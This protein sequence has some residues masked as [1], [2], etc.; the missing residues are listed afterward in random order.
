MF[1]KAALSRSRLA[2]VLASAF[3]VSA[4]CAWQAP[5]AGAASPA[6]FTAYHDAGHNSF[7]F[8][9]A[10]LAWLTG[11]RGGSRPTLR[12]GLLDTPSAEDLTVTS[13][14]TPFVARV[15]TWHITKGVDQGRL[16]VAPGG[17][18]TF[19]YTVN[20]THEI[21]LDSG[22]QV[23]GTIHV[24]NPN[25]FDAAGVDVTDAVDNGGTCTV[26]GD[27]VHTVTVPGGNT[28][29][30]NYTCT[31]ASAPSP[32]SGTN[33]AT[34]TWSDIGSPNTSVAAT[35]VF[36]FAGVDPTF[37][38]GS[39][40]V[41]DPQDPDGAVVGSVTVDD[42]SPTTF[43]YSVAYTGDP[44]GTCTSHTNTASLT[45]DQLQLDSA[46]QT[47]EVCVGAGLTVTKTATPSVTRTF[48]WGISKSVAETSQTVAPGDT[49]TFDYSVKVTHDGGSD[50][51]ETTGT[52]HVSNPNDWESI[53][54]DVTDAVDNGGLC[55]VT[56]GANVSIPA[57]GYVDLPYTCSY[58]SAPS[59]QDGANA[60]TATWDPAS[61]ATQDGS[62]SGSADVQFSTV[63]PTIVDGSVVVTD[64]LGG[65]LGTVSFSDPSPR[66]FT[67]Q[68]GFSGDPAGTCTSH[69]NT[70]TFTTS[71]TGTTGSDSRSVDVCVKSATADLTV[72]N[73]VAHAFF[74]RTYPWTVT[75]S[76]ASTARTSRPAAPARRSPTR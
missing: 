42:P 72:T 61:F 13:D 60:A 1:T 71:T 28:L 9:D 56:G 66:P 39:V 57:S 70:A 53:T 10:S 36:D 58:A 5:S 33:A 4:A 21:D 64:T 22:W 19:T 73:T 46:S 76:V 6:L 35:A 48:Q 31:Y 75:K 34:V 50:G 63:S 44:A 14:A 37:A 51:W 17:T 49:A 59:P 3:A 11:G 8:F 30:L 52:I 40:D 38:N 26:E 74:T 67:Y 69:P 41:M 32:S 24:H 20:V 16:D 15:V 25:T 68:H 23:Y 55:T 29:D 43:T 54:A 12:N 62:A 2:L 45:I 18:A 27:A 65:T 7:N 47:A